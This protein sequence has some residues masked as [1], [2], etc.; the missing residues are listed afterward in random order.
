LT[1]GGIQIKS[2]YFHG[3]VVPLEYLDVT[4]ASDHHVVVGAP[5]ACFTKDLVKFL[6]D[7]LLLD[8]T[9]EHDENEEED[10]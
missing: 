3:E 5:A 2:G 6:Q 7:S 4:I 9:E 8:H 1:I 10:G